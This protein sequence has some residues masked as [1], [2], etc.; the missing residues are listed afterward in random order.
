MHLLDARTKVL[1]KYVEEKD[2]KAVEEYAILSHRWLSQEHEIL[3]EDMGQNIE[4]KECGLRKKQGFYKLIQC[5]EQALRD[6]LNYIW[7]D[8]CCIDKSNSTEL[9]E[10]INSMYRYFA[11]AKIC[12]VYL[13]DTLRTTNGY[14]KP[15]K[16]EDWFERG[17]TLQELIAAKNVH[18][19]DKRWVYLGSKFDLGYKISEITGISRSVLCYPEDIKI[20]S[21]A[22]RMS[23]ASRRKTTRDEDLAYSLI[24]LFDVSMPMLYGE[25]GAKA[26][27]RLQEEIIKRSDDH[28]IFAW[29]GLQMF[30]GLLAPNPGAFD[31]CGETRSVQSR[32]G[33]SPFSMTNRGLS[34]TLNL[35]PWVLDTYLAC[36]NCRGVSNSTR[37]AIF[38][39]RN[40]ADD[41][42]SR[43]T[44]DGE[45]ICC[46]P[47][48][49]TTH[50]IPNSKSSKNIPIFVK[51]VISKE[52]ADSEEILNGFQIKNQLAE[53]SSVVGNWKPKS[54]TVTF[55][56]DTDGWR[57][58]A[59]LNL[60]KCG[61]IKVVKL[62][63][64]FDFNPVILLLESTVNPSIKFI[65]TS[66]IVSKDAQGVSSVWKMFPNV[67]LK[68]NH[69]EPGKW[70]SMKALDNP[71]N[72][73]WV[74]KG[75]RLTDISIVLRSLDIVLILR[76]RRISNLGYA[77]F[78]WT[79]TILHYKEWETK[80][81]SIL[82]T[83]YLDNLVSSSQ[84]YE[85]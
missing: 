22:Q 46:L 57:D 26:F 1:K 36:L 11:N 7:I 55:D 71:Y 20:F 24:G 61:K 28:S 39:R 65:N 67:P 68:W 34:I 23:W 53:S 83:P 63:F 41:Q 51:G 31:G 5:C 54:Q 49:Q 81:P 32:F 48:N 84:D 13:K 85:I 50:T 29:G 38:L 10:A 80:M 76:K 27:L 37:L 25:G 42:Y 69:V 12:Y 18:F 47:V 78:G 2:G 70:G 62:G 73:I 64:D 33:N 59:T 52:I 74:L 77:C 79:L 35:R 4:S 16:K 44:V 14:F 72:G 3:F 15:G 6:G 60:S 58:V 8:T 40:K 82:V 75:D 45:E 19:Y 30:N 21:I 43:V 17:W 66:P 9:Q 56:P